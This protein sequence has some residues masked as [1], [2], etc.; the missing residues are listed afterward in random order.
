MPSQILK[1]ADG[2]IA[3]SFMN[4][5]RARR[6]SCSRASKTAADRGRPRPAAVGAAPQRNRLA[7]AATEEDQ[8]SSERAHQDRDIVYFLKQPADPRVRLYHDYTETREGVNGYANVVRKGS[9]AS[10]PSASN[11]DTGEQ[12]RPSARGAARIAARDQRRRRRSSP[13]RASW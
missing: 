3:I 13:Q 11:L 10:N 7:T 12:L 5:F 6:H 1:R 2:R 9:T 4:R 8:A